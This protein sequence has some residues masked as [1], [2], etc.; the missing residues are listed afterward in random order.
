MSVVVQSSLYVFSIII[1]TTNDM[2]TIHII[3]VQ[4]VLLL[5]LNRRDRETSS[6]AQAQAPSWLCVY[7]LQSN[8]KYLGTDI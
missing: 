7:S 1:I 2:S 3:L 5:L 6:Q 4:S 8:N